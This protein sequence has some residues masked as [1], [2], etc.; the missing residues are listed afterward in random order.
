MPAI[1]KQLHYMKNGI[2]TDI[3]LYDS[4]G[5]VGSDYIG[6]MVDGSPVYA[7]LGEIGEAEASDLRIQKNG[8][9]YAVLKSNKI[10]LPTGFIAMFANSCPTGWV[11]ETDLDE[12]FIRGAVNYGGTGGNENHTH[13]YT[14]PAT[15]TD[16][17]DATVQVRSYD[18]ITM[19]AQ[20]HRHRS[21]LSTEESES[22]ST[23]PEYITVVFCKKV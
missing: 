1:L 5:D 10:D 11:R 14:I 13:Q 3:T 2:I 18:G 15:Y 9:T 21:W 19:P 23:L 16:Y 8:T 4:Q 7:K 22:G 6:L 12:K 17:A 20:S